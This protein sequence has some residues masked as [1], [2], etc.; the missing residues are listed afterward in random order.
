MADIRSFALFV[1]YYGLFDLYSRIRNDA[2][3]ARSKDSFVFR[4]SSSCLHGSA[5]TTPFKT[6]HPAKRISIA[7]VIRDGLLR[8]LEDLSVFQ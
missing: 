2:F 5:N 6:N 3:F 1:A 8:S 7:I 4:A